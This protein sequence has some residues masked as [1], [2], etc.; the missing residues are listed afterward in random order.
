M[1]ILFW[2]SVAF[3][4]YV[5]AG[6]PLLLFLMR[7]LR[8]R[9]VHKADIEPTVSLVIAAHNERDRIAAK[10]QNC[11]ELLYPR[12]KLQILVSLDGP[13]DGTEFVVWKYAAQGVEM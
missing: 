4:A 6:Y 5:Y 1:E 7:T 8:S 9:R 11:L 13:T 2:S 10:L 3:V 12:R